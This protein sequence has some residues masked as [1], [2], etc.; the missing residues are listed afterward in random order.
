MTNSIDNKSKTLIN[1]D[2]DETYGENI[3]CFTILEI[4]EITIFPSQKVKWSTMFSNFWMKFNLQSTEY[5]NAVKLK[6]FIKN[7]F[8]HFVQQ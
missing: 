5:I 4:I 3:W 7:H 1:S 8:F 2:N 6:Y